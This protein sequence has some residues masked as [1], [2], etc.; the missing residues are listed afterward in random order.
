VRGTSGSAR[1]DSDC[2]DYVHGRQQDQQLD[3]E[4][5]SLDGGGAGGPGLAEHRSWGGGEYVPSWDER[6]RSGCGASAE[7]LDVVGGSAQAEY[8]AWGY[9]DGSTFGQSVRGG[10][11]SL[12]D[13]RESDGPSQSSSDWWLSPQGFQS[14]SP[15][16]D[17]L[18]SLSDVGEILTSIGDAHWSH[19]EF[20]GYREADLGEYCPDYD[21]AGFEPSSD[22]S[23]GCEHRHHRELSERSGSQSGEDVLA[24]DSQRRDELPDASAETNSWSASE[25]DGRRAKLG[26]RWSSQTMLERGSTDCDLSSLPELG[27]GGFFARG[28]PVEGAHDTI[29]SA[30]HH[31]ADHPKSDVDGCSV[32]VHHDRCSQ[33]Q[34]AELASSR[35]VST[36]TWNEFVRSVS[37]ASSR[38]GCKDTSDVT[39]TDFTEE[40][41][42]KSGPEVEMLFGGGKENG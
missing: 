20:V 25:G 29:R 6:G 13:A 39:L 31:R 17:E 3:Q 22:A 40:D 38:S 42:D 5:S 8:D 12:R 32:G 19:E 28:G 9:S 24:E 37:G 21:S 23:L 4:G 34:L 14:Q 26:A 41:G 10:S 36:E 33:E 2:H 15:D 11:D 27:A 1:S 7:E 16:V 35:L 30:E 18:A